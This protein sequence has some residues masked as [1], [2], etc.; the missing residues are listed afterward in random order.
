MRALLRLWR[1]LVS[2]PTDEPIRLRV[3]AS[4]DA[5]ELLMARLERAA[6]GRTADAIENAWIRSRE[7][8]ARQLAEVIQFHGPRR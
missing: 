7:K 6:Q 1:S 2:V 3:G 5:D 8:K 4:F